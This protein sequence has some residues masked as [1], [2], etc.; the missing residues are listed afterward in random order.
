M[1]ATREQQARHQK[2]RRMVLA[3]LQT[4]KPDLFARW[5]LEARAKVDAERAQS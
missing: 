5:W 1:A 3:R 2:M 4:E